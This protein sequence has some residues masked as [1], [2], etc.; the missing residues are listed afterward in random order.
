[1]DTLIGSTGMPTRQWRV[2]VIGAAICAIGAGA[3]GSRT[4]LA[5]G[6]RKVQYKL[7]LPIRGVP[8]SDSFVHDKRCC[9]TAAQHEL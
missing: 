3:T 1:V 7:G 9:G 8:P 5:Q 4:A 2:F 6:T